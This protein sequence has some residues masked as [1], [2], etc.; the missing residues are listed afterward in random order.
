MQ[1]TTLKVRASTRK[2]LSES[3]QVLPCALEEIACETTSYDP[4]AYIWDYLDNCVL[5][6]VLQTEGVNMVVQETNY[7]INCGPRS[8]TKIV[9]EVKN[10]F[11]KL[12]GRPTEENY[13]INF[14]SHYFAIFCGVFDLGYGRNLDKERK[15]AIQPLQWKAPSETMDLF[16]SIHT[17]QNTRPT[18][19]AMTLCLYLWTTRCTWE[20]NW[21]TSSFKCSRLLLKYNTKNQYEQDRTHILAI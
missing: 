4:Y 2:I 19:R 12:F 18:K 11:K 13:P 21:T 14:D 20:Q 3:A 7:F 5:S 8:T 10:N 17:T 6:S 16:N 9:F 1:R 15:G